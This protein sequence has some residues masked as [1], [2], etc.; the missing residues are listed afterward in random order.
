M[1]YALQA[2]SLALLVYKTIDHLPSMVELCPF[3]NNEVFK[4]LLTDSVRAWADGRY[5]MRDTPEAVETG[6]DIITPAAVIM[7][8][9]TC[10]A[11]LQRIK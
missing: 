3:N 7:F 1:A 10:R 2:P 11:V 6:K 8:L 4:Q 9:A 5:D